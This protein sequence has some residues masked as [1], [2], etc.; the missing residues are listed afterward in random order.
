MAS[1]ITVLSKP[2]RGLSGT[3]GAE[4]HQIASNQTQASQVEEGLIL[5]KQPPSSWLQ[6]AGGTS[7]LWA[8]A[9]WFVAA[10]LGK[11]QRRL[12]KTSS[13]S[14]M[15]GIRGL[16]CLIVFNF[17]VHY[18]HNGYVLNPF[19][20][21]PLEVNYHVTQLPIL[22][23]IY[24]GR[25][26]VCLFFVLSGF[27]LSYSPLN[28]IKTATPS[29]FNDLVTGL[30]SS[31]LRRFIR[32][33]APM[34]IPTFLTAIATWYYPYYE[35]GYWRES[36]PTF[37]Q[38]LWQRIMII[39]PLFNPFTWDDGYRPP[40][41]DQCWTLALEYRGSMLIFLLCVTTARLTSRARKLTIGMT[42]VWGLYYGRW[43]VF[44]FMSG[45]FLAELRHA[46]LAT[47]FPSLSNFGLPRP[48]RSALA[49]LLMVGSLVLISW[50]DRGH[51]GIEP[52][53]TMDY[54]T[55]QMWKA[56]EPQSFFWGS[57]GALGLMTSFENLPL[58]QRL[59]ST[60]PMLW[61]GET[62]FSLYLLHWVTFSWFGKAMMIHF[63]ETLEWSRESSFY[64]MYFS[65]LAILFV[66]SD[67]YWRAV[68]E[69]CVLLG[70]HLVDWLGVR[71]NNT[72]PTTVVRQDAPLADGETKIE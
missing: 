31:I 18:F 36:D 23:V 53:K 7:R 25:A 28:K 37:A 6:S 71:N 57:V 51:Q 38:H 5:E 62:S 16:A 47:E 22:R 40:G 34:A 26:M 46:P 43:D 24:A 15:N 4:Y 56:D 68:D 41:M 55:P 39:M 42:A 17:H 44:C 54:Y 52:Y 48:V 50:P 19:G 29:S 69:K 2:F 66:A 3:R 35:P 21:E 14:Y 60:S 9:P 11:T 70:K 67:Y 1:I 59:F 33:F 20:A 45:M 64:V 58:M 10:P 63:T 61:L 32:L 72:L 8:L 49:V 12:P 65:V 30:S 13:T 27:V